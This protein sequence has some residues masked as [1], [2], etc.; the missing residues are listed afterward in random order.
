MSKAKESAFPVA[1]GPGNIHE[2]GMTMREYF[3]LMIFQSLINAHYTV[4]NEGNEVP[5][6]EVARL[7]V[8]QADMLL[9]VLGK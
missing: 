4:D 3:S 7:A 1:S 9:S 5:D 2:P 6:L 8:S